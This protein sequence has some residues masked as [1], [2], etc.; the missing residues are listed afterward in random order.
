MIALKRHIDLE[1]EQT[2]EKQAKELEQ[3]KNEMRLKEAR[4]AER[5]EFEAMRNQFATMADRL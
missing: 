1:K 5:K 2:L 4:D 3:L